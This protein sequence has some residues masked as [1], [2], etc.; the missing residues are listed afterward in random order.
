MM[1]GGVECNPQ[2]HNGI[3]III[4]IIIIICNIKLCNSNR[5]CPKYL[6]SRKVGKVC[7]RLNCDASA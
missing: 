5:S 7:T 2:Q 1:L 6:E 3:I 4:I